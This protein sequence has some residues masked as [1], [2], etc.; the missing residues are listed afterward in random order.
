MIEWIAPLKPL[1][2]PCPEDYPAR[3]YGKFQ[4]QSL[5]DVLVH[6]AQPQ[7]TGKTAQLAVPANSSRC[8]GGFGVNTG[9]VQVGCGLVAV[10]HAEKALVA[11]GQGDSATCHIAQRHTK[12]AGQY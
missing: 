8:H 2:P 6:G 12:G 5:V 11:A 7:C 3:G 9:Y 4:I 1:Q 10:D